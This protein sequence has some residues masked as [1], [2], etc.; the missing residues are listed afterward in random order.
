[1]GKNRLPTDYVK[2]L[3]TLKERIQTE[4]LRV[5]LAANSA[6]VLLYWD[7]GNVILERQQQEGWGAKVIDRLSADLRDAFPEMKGL[8]PRNLKYMRKFADAWPERE[9]VQRSV[10]QI[11]WRSNLALLDKLDNHE[12]RLWYAQKTIENGWSRNILAIQIETIY[13]KLGE[14]RDTSDVADVFKEIHRIVNQAIRANDTGVD[15][16]EGVTL[17]LSR[18]DFEKLREEF[19]KKV[20][21][22]KTA[23]EDIRK[24]VEKKLEQMLSKNPLRMGYYKKYQEIISDY[25][26]EKDRA[27]VEETFAKLEDLAAAMDAEQ[28]RAAEEGLNEDE[29][30]LFDLLRKDNISK[31]DRERVK[32][33]GKGLLESLIAL[34]EPIE[35]WTEKEQTQA[36]VKVPILDNLFGALP[37]PPYGDEETEKIANRIYDYVWQRSSVGNPLGTQVTG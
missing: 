17:D 33:A 1:M 3:K 28:R 2:V 34:L 25:N 19:A 7:I 36:E 37:D 13:K 31:A 4:R 11:P 27:T 21:R 6:M 10:A 15:Q 32:Q 8:S 16:A 18:I 30:A 26:R 12:T 14:R 23:L 35:S 29:L 5:T 22:K 20:R 9:F 24:I